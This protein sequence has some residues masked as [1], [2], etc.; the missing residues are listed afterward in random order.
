MINGGNGVWQNSTGNHNWTDGTGAINAGFSDGSFAIFTAAPGTVTIDNSLGAVNASG[1]QFAVDGYRLT[2]DPL[3]LTGAQALVRVG[4]GTAAGTGYTAT[5]DTILTGSAQLAKSDLGTL[6]LT[7]TNSYTGGTLI[8]AGTLRVGSDANLGDVSGGLA[9]DGGTLNTSA[10]LTSARAVTLTGA[11]T[12][13]TDGGTTATFGGLVSGG[14]DLMKGGAGTLV[15]AGANM[16]S[17]ATNVMAGTLLVN[18]DQ[19]AATGPTTVQSGATLGGAGKIGGNVAILDGATLA[20]GTS[21]AGTLAIAGDLTLGA[22]SALN[23]RFGQAGTVGGP[24]NDLVTVGGNLTLDGTI[25]VTATSGGSFGPGIYRVFNYGG[26]LTDGGL[27]LGSVPDVSSVSVQTSVAG[28]V[29]LVYASPIPPPPSGGG[30]YSFW[31]GQA[32]PKADGLIQGGSGT[33]QVAGS[34][35]N[36]TD[37]AGAANGGYAQGTFAIFAGTGGGVTIDNG[38]GAVQASGLQFAA[39]GYSVGGD[40]LTLTGTNAT[41]RVGDGTSAG[42]GFTAT[43]NA[44]IAGTAGI[45]KT[46]A[47]RLVL[48]GVNIYGGATQVAGG[49]LVVNGDQSGATGAVS[50]TSGATLAGTGKIG[51]S[52]TISDGATLAPGFGGAGTL[53]IGG[54]LSLGAASTVRFELGQA[55]TVGGSLNDL[56][57]VGGNLKLDGTLQV[58]QTVGGSFDPGVYRLFDYGGALTDNGLTLGGIA[59][60]ATMSLD[61]STAHQ[62]NLINTGGLTLNYWDAAGANNNAVNGG[63]GTWQAGADTSWT[64]STGQVNAPYANAAFAIFQG[65]AGTVTIDNSRAPVKASGMQFGVDGYTVTGGTLT[66][67]GAKST[68]RVGDGTAA[69]AAFNAT[70]SAP[71]AGDTQLVKADAGTLILAGANTYTGGTAVTGGTLQ[72]AS[73]ANLGAVA[74]NVSL[75]SGALRTSADMSSARALTLDGNGTINVNDG[76]SLTWNGIVAGS[77]GLTKAGAGMLALTADSST[78]A[79]A[80]HLAAGTLRVDGALGGIVAI[81]DK[82]KLQGNGRV[83]AVVNQTGGM[84]APGN[85]I[86]HLTITGDYVGAG[87]SLEI[88][89][90]LGG[91]ASPADLLTVQGATSGATDVTVI[92]RGGLG[93]QTVNG[94]KIIDVAGASAGSFALKG[95]Y[96][97]QGDQAV[98]AG[99]YGYRLYK[100]GV[101]TPADG[102]WYLRSTL[103][104]ATSPPQTPNGPLYQPGVPIY[105]VYPSTLLLLNG[106]DTMQQR[107]GERGYSTSTDGHLNGIW[108]RMQGQRFRPNAAAST[109]MA[110]AD[111]N[112]WSAEI[113]ADRVLTESAKGSTLTASISGRYGKASAQ[114]RSLFGNG[115]IKANGYGGRAA[116]TWQDKAGFYADAQAQF[117]WYDSNLNSSV[118]GKLVRGNDGRGQAYSLEVGKR[119]GLGSGISVTPQIQTVYSKV[120]FD[121]FTDPA[122]AD[123]SLGKADSL[124]TRWGVA[125]DRQNGGARFYAVG[126]LTYDWLGDT[127]ANVSGTPIARTDHRLWSEASVGGSVGVNDRLTLYGEATANTAVKDFGKSYGLKGSVGVRMKF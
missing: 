96:V 49:T 22:N 8:E 104:D 84:L 10:N 57:E 68:I 60:S 108:G 35:N 42:A 14:G 126:N 94:I 69:G 81:E 106:I 92:N 21:T 16:Y 87:G 65:T 91:D 63:N 99:A 59:N 74:G 64:N 56:L 82:A 39:N 113:G 101:T 103:L 122:G 110:D 76:T 72:I 25:N 125:I 124:K 24:L 80:T 12:I 38:N 127:I 1:M 31:D 43:I 95:D 115:S 102:D 89:A 36:W 118:L 90:A 11:G 111:Y 27:A 107:V 93:A 48:G 26:T 20:P 73:D 15:F 62:V 116:L 23:Y 52:V 50:V 4:D 79:G 114:V 78:Y 46:D 3:T 85:S 123:V 18:G 53:T 66:L 28:Q 100:G 51:G 119:V 117:S 9:F 34:A 30:T 58:S 41:L 88:E 75:N 121:R 70:I 6:V 13:Q 77:G 109:S 61:I 67:V 47:G 98:I 86:G 17:G 83:G 105:E 29:N 32:G 2:G 45:T 71:I 33:W 44:A 7:G 19:S 112:S 97:F 120:R 37:A 54:D 40:A 5:V 55:N